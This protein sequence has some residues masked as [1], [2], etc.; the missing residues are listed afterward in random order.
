M[1]VAGRA[2]PVDARQAFALDIGP[3]LP[4]ILADAALAAAMPAGDHR[5]GD[6][7]RLDQQS[8]TSEARSLRAGERIAR[9]GVGV[10]DLRR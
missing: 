3:E 2:A 9:D 10:D 5:V 6:A 1:V 4:E 8:G 7:A